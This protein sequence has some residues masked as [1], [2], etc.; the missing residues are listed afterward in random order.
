MP[1]AEERHSVSELVRNYSDTL[2]DGHGKR[3]RSESGDSAPAGKR[4]A[5]ERDPHLSPSPRNTNLRQY[6]DDALEKLEERLT[7]SISKD[8]HEFRGLISAELSAL[9]DRVRDLERHVEE[10]DCEVAQLT[11]EL[12]AA[13][14]NIKQLQDRAENSEMNSRI[15]CLI[16]SGKAMAPR[17]SQRL[18]APL[19]PTDRA[20]PQ[21]TAAHRSAGRAESADA[22]PTASGARAGA[23][24]GRSA[25]EER[26][27]EV[28]DVNGLVIDT[29]RA[30][31]PGLNISEDD[32]DRAH[33]LPGPNNKV[34]V[35]FV[36]SGP[37]S[38]RDQLMSR[39][40]E[41]RGQDLYINESLTAQ[42]NLI[43]RSLLDAKKEKKVYTVFT[44][45]GH[46]FYKTEKYGTSS[47]VDSV[48]KLREL[49]LPVKQ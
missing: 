9:N 47:R 28:E 30:R 8:L 34:I 20:A 10:K 21:G 4:G 19:P 17:R 39:R 48:D 35:R 1:S 15:P 32:I 11:T 13:K 26:T 40:L 37:G 3:D 49:G 31:L 38:V 18:D 46:V 25:G 14:D 41:L 29:V 12:A 22:R 42:K 44:R 6:L 2:S 24:S 45:W 27:T 16:L 33:R 7:A 23:R 5:R 36:R 43:Y